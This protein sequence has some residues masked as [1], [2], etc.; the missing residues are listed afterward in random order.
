MISFRVIFKYLMIHDI[1]CKLITNRFINI[2]SCISLT[3]SIVNFENTKNFLT[4]FSFI[5]LS[6]LI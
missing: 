1:I 2:Y 6:T 3:I 4:V 5:F